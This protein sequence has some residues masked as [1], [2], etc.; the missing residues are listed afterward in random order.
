MM[1]PPL[2]FK[3]SQL[4]LFA[5]LIAALALVPTASAKSIS[6]K[7]PKNGATLSR[8][9]TFTPQLTKELKRQAK[10]V[11]VWLGNSRLAVDS[12]APFRPKIDTRRIADGNYSFKVRVLIRHAKQAGIARA[13]A[14]T[15]RVKV[16]VANAPRKG[17]GRPST[18]TK[19]LESPAPVADP[20]IGEITS[21]AAN[22]QM[23]F[24]D[25]F[26]GTTL[27]TSKWN[28]QRDDWLKGGMPYNNLE[29]AWYKPENSTVGGGIL[30]QTIQ[31]LPST[32]TNDHGTFDYSTGM[33][34]S[35]KRFG[36]TYGYV[37]SRMRVPSCSGCWPAFWMLPVKEGWPPEIDIYEFFD[38]ATLKYPYFSSHWKGTTTDQEYV[39]NT[40]GTPSGDYTEAWHTYGMLWTPDSVQSFVDGIPGP[41]YTGKAVPHEAMYLIMQMAIGK[42]Y[43][44]PAGANLQTDY[45]RV[46]Q[47]Q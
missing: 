34:N 41:T 31:R 8:T 42:G 37:E 23:I 12:R 5:T 47:Q 6:V 44:T 38:S 28:N 7:S 14:L 4:F 21:G 18:P 20:R 30:K 15:R 3:L 40:Y 25:E 22:W 27:D 35:N 36:F 9:A 32:M 39:T 24:S 11:E 2:R 33:V 46:Y 19:S 45:V 16:T 43:A 1:C 26:D 17:T 10:R 13:R 29:G